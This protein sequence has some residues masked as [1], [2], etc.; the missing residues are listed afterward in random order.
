[1]IDL[2]PYFNP[3]L[4]RSR[5][6]LVEKP[7]RPNELQRFRTVVHL[8]DVVGMGLEELHE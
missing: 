8:D 5:R 6:K 1:M 4:Q 3:P 7:Y 2:D